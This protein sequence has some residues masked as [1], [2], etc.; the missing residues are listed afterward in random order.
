MANANTRRTAGKHAAVEGAA[1]AAAGWVS[2]RQ[3]T[4]PTPD[5][6][7]LIAE[8]A[9]EVA[10]GF[11]D[12]IAPVAPLA[13]DVVAVESEPSPEAD[14]ILA[15]TPPFGYSDTS[16]GSANS[17]LPVN[18]ADTDAVVENPA[19]DAP[20]E[21]LVF[22]SG[23]IT[24]AETTDDAP[25]AVDAVP[26]VFPL[27]DI[28]TVVASDAVD[29][30]P[31]AAD[32][33][34]FPTEA[35][36]AAVEPTAEVDE[37]VTVEPLDDFFE[38]GA[39]EVTEPEPEPAA[40]AED[41]EPAPSGPSF[42]GPDF[43]RQSVYIAP[44]VAK[45]EPEPSPTHTIIYQQAPAEPQGRTPFDSFL[46][47]PGNEPAHHH[48]TLGDVDHGPEF[49]IIEPEKDPFFV[50]RG[51]PIGA[52]NAPVVNTTAR[53]TDTPTEAETHKY[54]TP[55]AEEAAAYKAENTPPTSFPTTPAAIKT[56]V[57]KKADPRAII[58]GVN[59]RTWFGETV[60][61]ALGEG[62]SDIHVTLDGE[63]EHLIVRARIDGI[64]REYTQLHGENAQR[65][66][67]IFKT[68]AGF[69][70]GT[71]F[72]PEEAIYSVMVDGDERKARAVLF[73]SHDGGDAL[74]MRLPPTGEIRKLD[75]LEFSQKNLDLF[76]DLL[77]SANRML[78]I[79]G[80]MGSGKTTTS[81]AALMHVA[82]ADRVVWTIEDPVE[83]VLP[84]LT[85][86]EV[87]DANGAGFE[88]YLPSLVRADYDTLFLG[89]IRDKATA[90]AGVR[91]AKA[92]R[93]VIS[94]IHSNDNVTAVLRLI[95]LAE[96]SPLSVMDAIKGVV[97]Q[98]LVRRLNKDWDG[99]DENLKYKGRVPIHEVLMMN[100]ELV[101]VVMSQRPLSE[102]KIAAAAA[103]ASTFAEDAKRLIDAGVTD[104]TE[105]KRVL[106]E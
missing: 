99:E 103:S 57:K 36:E 40:E 106:S 100:D 35:H 10:A 1:L 43:A 18:P 94:T 58:D 51:K 34:V 41:E 91:Q 77:I 96:D 70:S 87:D 45:P 54:D 59:P 6:E 98:R 89:E 64:M 69:A 22:P 90:A 50:W 32:V 52:K 39:G 85:Q 38:S 30:P 56:P 73:R 62:S 9:A 101:E 105:V 46:D 49:E 97:S 19:A 83:R 28:E 88:T 8:V 86:L 102:I 13:P 74:V 84:G 65:V 44:V 80:P 5:A 104:A 55:I 71:S 7:E 92:G 47:E 72:V 11:E 29:A 93:Q 2:A 33:L 60:Q 27:A 68:G 95:E 23:D 31:A 76:H 78:L 75:D 53:D 25:P 3:R 67:G 66:M 14:H 37:A 12:V 17:F 16:A 21:T 61:K 26:L 20:A 79:A 63:K 48:D 42:F 24:V 15:M 81:H 82:T 4:V